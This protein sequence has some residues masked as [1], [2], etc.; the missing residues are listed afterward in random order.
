GSFG[1]V[2]PIIIVLILAQIIDNN[3]IEPLVEGNSLN[4]S[5]IITIVAIVLG[6]LIWGIAGM[7]LFIPMFAIL[8]IICDH[9]PALHSYGYLL[10]ND[11]KEPK[12]VEKVKGFFNRK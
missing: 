12:W 11:V 8:R 4:L 9:I 7:I 2:L 5:P 6:E 1:M 3:I 10:R